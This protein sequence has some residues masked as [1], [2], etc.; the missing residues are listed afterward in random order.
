MKK[1]F[2]LIF[3]LIAAILLPVFGCGQTENTVSSDT[4]TEAEQTEPEL[5]ADINL[6]SSETPYKIIRA[7]LAGQIV[8]DASVKLKK[9]LEAKY[10]TA[11]TA[12]IGTDFVMGTFNKDVITYEA[13]EILIGSTN[14]QQ[15]VDALSGLG[16]NEYI[17]KAVDDKLLII[18][19]NDYATAVAVDYFIENYVNTSAADSLTLSTTLEYKGVREETRPPLAEGAT[20]RLLSYNLGC[21]VGN[22]ADAI[23]ILSKYMPDLIG[24][25]ES[26][27][28]IHN[29]VIG[30]FITTFKEYKFAQKYHTGGSTLCYTPI[31]YNSKKLT[32]VKAGVE[33][34]RSR[35]TGTN[36]KSLAWAVFDTKDGQRFAMINFHGAV[37]SA[38]YDEY[39][40]LT[41]SDRSALALKFRI[42]NANQML[43]IKDMIYASYGEIPITINGD[44]NFNS[45]SE[46]FKIITGAGFTDAET[47]AKLKTNAGYKTSFSYKNG[48]P[49]TGQSIDH[50]FGFGGV[51]FAGFTIIRD[52]EVSTASDHC[53]IYADYNPF[54]K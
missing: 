5:P 16:E 52:K 34:L 18:G 2:V 12:G 30:V 9:A 27:K 48:T 28:A 51:Y 8:T 13:Y 44:C 4:H 19:E 25:Q 40:N 6:L 50:I 26:N 11:F 22:N 45:S 3:A 32:L 54:G 33:W 1:K 46:P 14:R 31:V 10:G 20:L 38:D 17:I 15:S 49:G 43:E 21:D 39:K 42:D 47:T 37:V 53:P 41:D 23:A 7:D 35:Y 24:F 36:T 29:N